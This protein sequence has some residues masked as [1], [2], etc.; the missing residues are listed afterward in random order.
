[1]PRKK[2][3]IDPN[4]P[5]SLHPYLLEAAQMALDEYLMKHPFGS[6]TTE[7]TLVNMLARCSGARERALWN[8]ARKRGRLA[9]YQRGA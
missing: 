8:C 5:E 3:E 2:A 7:T 9:P 6:E 4:S 1:M